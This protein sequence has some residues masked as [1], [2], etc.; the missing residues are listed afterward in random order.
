[1]HFPGLLQPGT[2]ATENGTSR[3]E[4]PWWS[5]ERKE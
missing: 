1:M 4:V 3:D 5:S 2:S